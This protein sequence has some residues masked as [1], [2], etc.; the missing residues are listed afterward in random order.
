MAINN[1]LALHKAVATVAPIVGI[2]SGGT[3]GTDRID[4]APEATQPQIEA[5]NAIL[6]AWVDPPALNPRQFLKD[7]RR[8]ATF[9]EWRRTLRVTHS[10]AEDVNDLIA[11][12]QLG[13]YESAQEIYDELKLLETPTAPQIAEWQGIADA[14]GLGGIIIF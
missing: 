9:K 12:A 4:F 11:A 3:G 13:E 7:L 10:A 1:L 5:A 8:S 2:G 6:A 14:N